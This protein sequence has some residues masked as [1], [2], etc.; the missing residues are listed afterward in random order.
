MSFLPYTRTNT[1]DNNDVIATAENEKLHFEKLNEVLINV[2]HTA[3]ATLHLQAY[4]VS[5]W[6][7]TFNAATC[8]IELLRFG[9]FLILF[10]L[11]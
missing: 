9:F 10:H 7:C 5:V 11:H 4:N 3:T 1:L 2:F 8:A 6:V